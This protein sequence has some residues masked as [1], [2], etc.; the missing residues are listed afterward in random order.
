MLVVVAGGVEAVV[1]RLIVDW[2]MESKGRDKG[3]DRWF[4]VERSS[5]S[6]ERRRPE[7]GS[8]ARQCSANSIVVRG[9]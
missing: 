1:A 2:E 6:W 5:L 3:S 8:K 9:E 4:D 7:I